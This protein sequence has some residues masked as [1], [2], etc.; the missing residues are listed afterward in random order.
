MT[1][2]ENITTNKTAKE[3]YANKDLGYVMITKQ[4][5]L[6]KKALRVQQNHLF[7]CWPEGRQL[8]CLYIFVELQIWTLLCHYPTKY[9]PYSSTLTSNPTASVICTDMIYHMLS[10]YHRGPWK[11]DVYTEI[12]QKLWGSNSFSSWYKP[13]LL[14]LPVWTAP[15][16]SDVRNYWRSSCSDLDGVKSC[17]MLCKSSSPSIF[18]VYH[19]LCQYP[20]LV[21]L[22]GLQGDSTI[23]H[24]LVYVQNTS[25][26][27]INLFYPKNSHSRNIILLYYF[28][29]IYCV[30]FYYILLIQYSLK[31]VSLLFLY[32]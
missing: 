4:Q 16:C 2:F 8:Q 20:H 17:G 25:V 30:Y 5:H 29:Y 24:M 15:L 9:I 10:V 1:I 3:D 6:I 26:L 32:F 18:N 11:F 13:A 21:K 31:N 7:L 27:H 19:I 12:G 22:C 23:Q 28:L 14:H